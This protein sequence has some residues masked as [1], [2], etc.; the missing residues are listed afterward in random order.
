[1]TWRAWLAG[2]ALGASLAA[3]CAGAR[4]GDGLEWPALHAREADGGES[5]A[6]RPK[7]QS[8]AAV[9]SSEDHTPAVV[10][11]VPA[12]PAVAAAVPGGAAPTLTAPEDVITT[13][14]VVIQVDE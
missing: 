14:D 11:D 2:S 4:R 3:G 5:L 8:A 6:P 12:V 10:A 1:M 7:T 13:E 9:A